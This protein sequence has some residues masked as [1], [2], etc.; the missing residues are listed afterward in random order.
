MPYMCSSCEFAKLFRM[1]PYR[2]ESHGHLNAARILPC[3]RQ[4]FIQR[5]SFIACNMWGLLNRQ[6]TEARCRLC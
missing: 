6:I 4:I 3:P 5:S 1:Q 2:Q